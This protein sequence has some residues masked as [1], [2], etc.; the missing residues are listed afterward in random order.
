MPLVV[1]HAKREGAP[2]NLLQV[3]RIARLGD[4][5]GGTQRPRMAGIAVLALPGEDDNPDLRDYL[6]QV[7]D[8]R[9]ALVGTMCQRRQAKVDQCQFGRP[10]QLPQQL[11]TVRARVASKH[12]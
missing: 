1:E 7:G 10:P 12:F 6:E 5:I 3:A 2:E 8:Q 11:Q 4:E 9:E